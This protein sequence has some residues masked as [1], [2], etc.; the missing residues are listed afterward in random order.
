MRATLKAA[1]AAAVTAVL[2]AACGSSETP[3]PGATG[4]AAPD[5]VKVGVIP[6]VD[7][8]PALPRREAGLLQ[9]AAAST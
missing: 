9:R 6:I 5:N 1:A 3:A 7:V 2:L 4:E 8:A